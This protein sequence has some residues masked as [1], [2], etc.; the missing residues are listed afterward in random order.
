MTSFLFFFYNFLSIFKTNEKQTNI[1]PFIFSLSKCTLYFIY[2][3]SCK[4]L[5][6]STSKFWVLSR[7]LNFF[8]KLSVLT[9]PKQRSIMHV[10]IFYWRYFVTLFW[11]K[12]QQITYIT[13]HLIASQNAS[14][15]P[16]VEKI[17]IY[18]PR[19]ICVEIDLEICITR[20]DALLPLDNVKCINHPHLICTPRIALHTHVRNI[21]I[22]NRFASKHSA[23]K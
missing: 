10:Y 20:G 21:N 16:G 13:I 18:A 2:S 5:L 3:L 12:V 17:I 19:R 9:K 8:S 7:E 15:C 1:G 23:D 11:K 22:N 6:F 14:K 4:L